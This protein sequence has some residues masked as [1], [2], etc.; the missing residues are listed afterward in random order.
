MWASKK[1]PRDTELGRS[2]KCN[3]KQKHATTKNTYRHA[4]LSIAKYKSRLHQID[5]LFCLWY[6][7]SFNMASPS[8]DSAS[9]S[10]QAPFLG[11]ID[12]L[13]VTTPSAGWALV[14]CTESQQKAFSMF[15]W[16]WLGWIPIPRPAPC[17][18]NLRGNIRVFRKAHGFY[19][20]LFDFC[21]FSIL[22]VVPSWALLTLVSLDQ[23]LIFDHHELDDSA[24]SKADSVAEAR[25]AAA[26]A[27]RRDFNSGS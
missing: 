5:L 27:S 24:D 7:V 20:S 19:V 17:S 15:I 14:S 26:S 6:Y 22:G 2:K 16:N 10:S 23:R 12:F 4:S 13:F 8:L 11:L 18:Q 9:T 1:I 3:Q 25:L 21:W